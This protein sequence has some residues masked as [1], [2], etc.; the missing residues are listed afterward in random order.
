LS[1]FKRASEELKQ[2]FTEEARNHE[3]KRPPGAP[4]KLIPPGA[5][6]ESYPPETNTAETEGTSKSISAHAAKNAVAE[7]KTSPERTPDE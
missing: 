7:H 3:L 6:N 4:D 2:T 5:M 1:E